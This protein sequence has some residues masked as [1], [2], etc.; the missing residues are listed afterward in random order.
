MDA[1]DNNPSAGDEATLNALLAKA[2]LGPVILAGQPHTS[3]P[4]GWV[5]LPDPYP[6]VPLDAPVY[7]DQITGDVVLAARGGS[8]TVIGPE[9]APEPDPDPEKR[10]ARLRASLVRAEPGYAHHRTKTS[11]RKLAQHRMA[12]GLAPIVN[13]DN[14]VAVRGEALSEPV[15]W[16]GR[17]WAVTAFGIERRDGCYAIEAARL[18]EE[19]PGWTHGSHMAWKGWVDMPDFMT[20]LMVARG[21][22][23][24]PPE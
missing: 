24:R 10:M 11:P 21:H 12:R 18:W 2:G 3:P 9:P 16:V 7:R 23:G 8:L 5:E 4:S 1:T 15:I 19:Y 14:T 13:A 17:Q 22:F 6:G 20:A